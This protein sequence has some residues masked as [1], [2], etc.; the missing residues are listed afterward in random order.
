MMQ[1]ALVSI[2]SACGT[3]QSDVSMMQS[4]ASARPSFPCLC[5]TVNITRPA[6]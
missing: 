5:H 6:C 3:G 4:H 2:T 1:R